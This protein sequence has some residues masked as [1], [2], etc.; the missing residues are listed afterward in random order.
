MDGT[1]EI[2]TDFAATMHE[3]SAQATDTEESRLASGISVLISGIHALGQR[4]EALEES[5]ARQFEALHFQKIE[6][7]LTA[8][9][10]TE[11]VNQKL[12][13]SLHEELINYR[14]NFV[15]DS[16]QKPVI[17]DL[18]VLFDDLSKIVEQVGSSASPENGTAA[19]QLRDNLDNTLHFLVEIFHRLEVTE[20]EPKETIDRNLHRVISIEKA[21]SA[22]EDGRIVKRLKRGFL[23]R[24]KVLRAEEVV[25]RRFAAPEETPPN[26]DGPAA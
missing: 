24:D 10:E 3:L 16:L 6:Q 18:V 5:M 23:W 2:E 13:D 26:S 19:A 9:R 14:D 1:T 20:I 7:Q 25:V 8:I 21:N 17:R 15:R 12:F 4:M 22:E 11:S